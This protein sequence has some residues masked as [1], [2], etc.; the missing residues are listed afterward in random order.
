MANPVVVTG[1]SGNVGR[2]IVEHLLAG[3]IKPRVV[4]RGAEK[5]AALVARGAEAHVGSLGDSAF[6][7]QAFHGASAA[8]VVVPPDY[9]A[10]DPLVSQRALIEGLTAA[11][12][13]SGLEHV[14]A[15]SSVGAELAAGNG[16]I[17]TLHVLEQ[18]LGALPGLNV[19]FLR[20][21]YFMENHLSA[22]GLIKS[23]GINGG[24]LKGEVP[25]PMI[26]TQDIAA[27]AATLLAKPDFSGTSVRFLL[28]P[29]DYT[30]ADA[31]RALGA[32]IGKPDLQYVAFPY[33][34]ARK[35]MLASGLS[36][37]LA[38]LFVEMADAFNSGRIAIESRT[39]TNTTPTTIEEFARTIFAPAFGA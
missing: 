36:P 5:L 10:A 17:R 2:R 14:V 15:L 35:G 27:V 23:A 37:V 1:A 34:D 7:K 20:A 33:D 6:L 31:T 28:G 12:R 18:Q 16:P 11:V 9:A 25:M 22:I 39:A 30:Q 32:A 8:F 19:V 29:K 26:A 24:A 38:D 13:D 3:G 4:A 21:A